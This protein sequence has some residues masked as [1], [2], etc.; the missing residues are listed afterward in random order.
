MSR[1]AQMI[2]TQVVV[3]CEVHDIKKVK[4]DC[5]VSFNLP[6]A[7]HLQ[8]AGFESSSAEHCAGSGWIQKPST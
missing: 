3:W 8:D 5:E 4:I 6:T 7:R 1:L 2:S